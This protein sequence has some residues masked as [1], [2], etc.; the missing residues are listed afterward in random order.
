MGI[1]PFHPGDRS[2]QLDRP[3]S[4]QIPP[5]MSDARTTGST[6]RSRPIPATTTAS[7]LRIRSSPFSLSPPCYSTSGLRLSDSPGSVL[8]GFFRRGLLFGASSTEE[9]RHAVIPLV[10]RILIYRPRCPRQGNCY[11]PGSRKCRW[12]V[13]CVLVVDRV[14]VDSCEAFDQV[15]V[16]AGPLHSNCM[17]W[18]EPGR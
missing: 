17:R 5:Q 11:R 1:Y 8:R 4:R 12:I 14:S 6:L 9:I 2:P 15:Q 7:F 10:T 16:R 13:D 18:I 3:F